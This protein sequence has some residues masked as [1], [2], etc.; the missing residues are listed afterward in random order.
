MLRCATVREVLFQ[1]GTSEIKIL[2]GGL[3]QV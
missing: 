2:L 3:D 1:W